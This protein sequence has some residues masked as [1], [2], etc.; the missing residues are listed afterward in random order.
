MNLPNNFD[1]YKPMIQFYHNTGNK[2]LSNLNDLAKFYLEIKNLALCHYSVGRGRKQYYFMEQGQTIEITEENIYHRLAELTDK[3]IE[4]GIFKLRITPKLKELRKV[5][6]G[7][8]FNDNKIRVSY[9][10]FQKYCNYYYDVC[11]DYDVI[12]FDIDIEFDLETAKE[13]S[14]TI[15]FGILFSPTNTSSLNQYIKVVGFLGIE[16]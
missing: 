3:E 5:I 12:E 15:N 4:A 16:I 10:K 9:N 13:V 11:K 2:I 8:K 7:N 6:I 1:K 14:D